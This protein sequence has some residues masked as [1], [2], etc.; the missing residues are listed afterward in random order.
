MRVGIISD[1]H[2]N[3]VALDGVLDDCSADQLDQLVC[4]GDL[5]T[6]GPQPRQVIERLR[7]LSVPVVMGNMDAWALAPKFRKPK[8][9]RARCIAEIQQWGVSQLTVSDQEFLRSL[10]ATVQVLPSAEEGLGLLC[11]HESPRSYDE[12]ISPGMSDEELVEALSG[13]RAR[14]MV[15][16]HTHTQMLRPFEDISIVNPGSVGA[17]KSPAWSEYAVIELKPGQQHVEL[18]RLQMDVEAAV[19]AANDSCMPNVEWWAQDRA[20]VVPD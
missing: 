5:I 19:E 11:Y 8:S 1:I 20:G 15:G 9:N 4:L 13:H 18:R 3:C 7:D 17:P 14:V 16:G 10:R 6:V 12:G 2:G